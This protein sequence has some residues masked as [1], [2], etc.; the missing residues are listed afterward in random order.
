MQKAEQVTATP[1]ET[2]TLSDVKA[3]RKIMPTEE[4]KVE[5]RPLSDP[6]AVADLTE[7][8][9]ELSDADADANTMEDMREALRTL[10][11]PLLGTSSSWF[12]YHFVRFS[13]WIH[14]T[15]I[16]GKPDK[17][18]AAA[19]ITTAIT[20]LSIIGSTF[21]RLLI[22]P[23]RLGPKQLQ[24]AGLTAMAAS[25]LLLAMGTLR[26][27]PDQINED[28]SRSI[29]AKST[30]AHTLFTCLYTAQMLADASGP[31]VTHFLIPTE[32]FPSTLRSTSVSIAAASG[33]LGAFLGA[34]AMPMI[35]DRGGL[36]SLFLVT[37]SFSLLGA[38]ATATLIPRYDTNDLQQLEETYRRFGATGVNKL[39]TPP[40]TSTLKVP[41]KSVAEQA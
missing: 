36:T 22:D 26:L 18:E 20:S 13:L 6:D 3:E 31:F 5:P 2:T 24:L 30:A 12:L 40:S 8:L 4:M 41:P 1:T 32:I 16:L 7:A 19:L 10:W 39:Y 15:D 34:S 33:S 29:D 11:K 9:I 28:G 37:G 35:R 23:K 38:A 27:W 21:A 14:A 25:H 17:P